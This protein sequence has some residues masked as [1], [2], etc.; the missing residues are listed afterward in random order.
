MSTKKKSMAELATALEE[1]D[2]SVSPDIF[3]E[4][5][6]SYCVFEKSS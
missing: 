6:W 5:L 4:A 2:G 1:A 3:R